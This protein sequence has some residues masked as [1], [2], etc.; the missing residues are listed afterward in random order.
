MVAS[1]PPGRVPECVIFVDEHA[2]FGLAGQGAILQI[3]AIAAHS[4]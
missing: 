1:L 2:A 4:S 3:A